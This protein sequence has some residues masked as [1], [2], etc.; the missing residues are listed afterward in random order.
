M[1]RAAL[2]LAALTALPSVA[3]AQGNVEKGKQLFGTHKCTM[4]HSIDGKG[5]AKGPLDSVGAKLTAAEIRQWLVD[6]AE[7]T[8]KTKAQRKPPMKIKPLPGD[9]V[10]ALVAY[11]VTLKK[12]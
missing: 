3:F 8:K 12:K 6:P 4:C 7:M 1:L 5:N 11:L 2:I 9:D 10:D